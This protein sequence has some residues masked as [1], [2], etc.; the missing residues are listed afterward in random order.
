MSVDFPA[1]FSPM[2]ACTSPALS[3]K[4]TLS[5]ARTPGKRIVMPRISTTGAALIGT[6]IALSDPLG[7]TTAPEPVGQPGSGAVAQH[8]FSTLRCRGS[9]L[10]GG[11]R[12]L[13]L[14]LVECAVHGEV[15]LL[16]RRACQNLLD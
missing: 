5:R 12:S 13:G 10:A 7:G 15:L 9:V 4:S 6:D 14:L 3:R 16:H 2:S 8:S 11:E 1:P